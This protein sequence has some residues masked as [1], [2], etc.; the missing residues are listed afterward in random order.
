[1]NDPDVIQWCR[2]CLENL[3]SLEQVMWCNTGF[4]SDTFSQ[5][6]PNML[7]VRVAEDNQDR[8]SNFSNF[9]QQN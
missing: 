4:N 1:V 7:R 9:L 3:N 2:A 5:D 8:M 6:C